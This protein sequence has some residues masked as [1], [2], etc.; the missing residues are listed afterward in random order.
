MIKY[1]ARRKVLRQLAEFTPRE[2]AHVLRFTIASGV[3]VDSRIMLALTLRAIEGAEGAGR[4]VLLKYAE[5]YR[6]GRRVKFGTGT[7][8]LE[9][10]TPQLVA[11]VESAFASSKE[12]NHD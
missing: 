8:L 3:P 9:G 4:S 2:A 12:T 5:A 7:T 10:E 11:E 6:A 1:F